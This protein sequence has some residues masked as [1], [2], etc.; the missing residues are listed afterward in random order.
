MIQPQDDPIDPIFNN[1]FDWDTENIDFGN[2]EMCFLIPPT[3]LERTQ[4]TSRQAQSQG[5]ERYEDIDIWDELSED[6]DEEIDWDEDENGQFTLEMKVP[7]TLHGS[8]IGFKGA[9][10]RKLENDTGVTIKV[11]QKT[12]PNGCV[13]LTG[14]LPNAITRCKRRIEMVLM[15]AR[16][17]QPF[18]HFI[19]IPMSNDIIRE[20]FDRFKREV[21]GLGQIRGVD[22][23]IF[24]NPFKLHLTIG[25][26]VVRN[27]DIIKISN[28][29]LKLKLNI[30]DELLENIG[31]L[32]IRMKGLEYMNDDPTEV[33]VLYAKAEIEDDK[34]S[35]L[36]RISDELIDYLVEEDLMFQK[37]DRVKLH[38][39]LMNTLFRKDRDGLKY[40]TEN[41]YD[42]RYYRE[43]ETFDAQQILENFKDYDF[44]TKKFNEIHLSIRKTTANRTGYYK[45]AYVQEF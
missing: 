9:M 27:E 29:F 7:K 6:E 3:G 45:S 12:D 44:G 31:P 11:P 5:T 37:Y 10:R 20:N 25:T 23:T 32:S 34:N 33:D 13:V 42:Q 21:L 28:L 22:S 39:T 35:L 41:E 26:L 8:I 4:Q 40:N 2:F 30:L 15:D 24:Q 14:P 38:V 19:S 43:R 1:P 36:Q 16:F 17:K 18:T